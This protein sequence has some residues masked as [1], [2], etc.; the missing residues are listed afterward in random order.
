[1]RNILESGVPGPAGAAGPGTRAQR[2][3]NRSRFMTLSHAATK[4]RDE[5]LAAR[6]RGVDLGERAQLGVRAED[7]VDRGGGPPHLAGRA[8]AALV[9]VL[10]GRPTSS[11]PCPCRA[12]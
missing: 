12:G 6:R 11:T 4:S 7:E 9:D 5:L 8:V 2:R 1:M 10:L 3:S